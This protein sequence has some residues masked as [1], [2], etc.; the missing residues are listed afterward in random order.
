M[1]VA[2]KNAKKIAKAKKIPMSTMA[3]VK[4]VT[5]AMIVA[6]PP[7]IPEA[8]TKELEK[9]T[10]AEIRFLQKVLNHPIA[11]HQPNKTTREVLH[12]QQAME[13]VII[14]NQEDIMNQSINRDLYVPYQL[15]LI[16]LIVPTRP[17]QQPQPQ[18]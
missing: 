13:D 15:V 2:S 9:A 14:A 17:K 12:P 6:N 5:R 7:M 3:P 10:W 8:V 16:E 4:V 1:V 18:P 11:H